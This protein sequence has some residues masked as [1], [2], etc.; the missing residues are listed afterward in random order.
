MSR[1]DLT[2]DA[3]G[4]SHINGCCLFEWSQRGATRTVQ[5]RRDHCDGCIAELRRCTEAQGIELVLIGL[6]PDDTGPLT[7]GGGAARRKSRPPRA[8]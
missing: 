5:L 8:A 1:S 2:P 7:I 6:D 4:T 3:L